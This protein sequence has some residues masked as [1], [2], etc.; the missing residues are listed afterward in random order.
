MIHYTVP[1][2]YFDDLPKRVKQRHKKKKVRS[3]MVAVA[4]AIALIVS[5]P[6]LLDLIAP[7]LDGRQQA[8]EEYVL[9]EVE[10]DLVIETLAFNQ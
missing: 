3:V 8:L 6:P 5:I 10:T 4:I 2:G 9:D 1:H 7:E